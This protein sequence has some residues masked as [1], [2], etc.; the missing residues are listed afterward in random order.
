MEAILEMKGITKTFGNTRALYNIDFDLNAGEVHALL[1]E[2]GAG[3]STL[4]KVLGGIHKPDTGEIWI[5]GKMTDIGCVADARKEG[6]GII[7]QEIFLVQNLT[8]AENIFLGR[9]LKNKKGYID[10]RA[11]VK[12]AQEMLDNLHIR[13]DASAVVKELAIGQQQLIE[14]VKAV[15]FDVK[16]LVLDEPTSSLS[17]EEV[18]SL[19]EL[20]DRLKKKKVGMI[21]ISHR[22]DELYK[23][24][25]RI[26]VMRDGESVATVDTASAKQDE[27]VRLMV[28]RSMESFYV[29]DYREPGEVVLKVNGLSKK[30]YFEDVSFEVCA[31]EIVG[32]SGLIGAGRSEIMRTV[33]GD[34]RPDSGEIIFKG[35]KTAWRNTRDA[36]RS[37][38][39]MVPEDRKKLGLVLSNSVAYNI[40][41]A[42]IKELTK[43]E[44][45]N[46]K[47]TADV[48][49]KAVKDFSIKTASVEA[50][51]SSLS[52]GNQQKVLLSKWI[53]TNPALLI[54]DEPTRGI[55][56]GAKQEIYRIM[57][58]LVNRGMA[59]ILISSELPEIV[60]MS[61]VVYVVRNGRIRKRFERHSFNQ[62]NIMAY[63]TG[64]SANE[65]GL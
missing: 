59:I 33:F 47:K 64:G 9:E 1:G 30:E 57:N 11:E 63:A 32:F 52:G 24:T 19:F 23:V 27:L 62:E 26:T 40:C 51:V 38:L 31:G 46:R 60:N 56:V 25:D 61:D 65:K 4:I 15:S 50:L 21:Y 10:Y 58:E 7:H 55:D 53:A 42:C 2:N 20:M 41:L 13:L 39:G 18:N 8:I 34:L 6:I 16:I 28:G 17:E 22:F 44:V 29:K 35:K 36:I 3:K 48:V 45:I 49:E 12:K 43:F 54:L 14:I 37:G 5:N